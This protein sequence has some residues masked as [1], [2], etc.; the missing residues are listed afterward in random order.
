MD[1]KE[2]TQ[3]VRRRYGAFA[4]TGGHKESCCAAAAE[5]GTGYA[6]DQ[7]LYGEADLAVVPEGALDLSRG[8]GNPTG[9]AGLAA[10][11]VVVDFGCGGGIDV[12]L[13]AHKV[14]AE[15]RVVGVDM[16]PQMIE[17]AR[18]NA[19]KAGLPAEGVDFR[20]ADLT[21]TGLPDGAADVVISN[22][23]I[24]LCPDK[25]SVY[26]EAFR[27][28]RPG[29]RV[30]ISDVVLSEPI[31]PE[32]QERFRATWAGCMGGAVPE[33]NYLEM[34]GHSGFAQVEV[35]SRHP[36]ADTELDAMA[37]CPGPEFAPAVDPDDLAPVQGKVVSIKFTAVKP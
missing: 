10:G 2:I 8:C 19:L 28:L 36:L 5:A 27:L 25:E 33:A 13:A 31:D 34:V 15:G 4:E 23:V 26:R 9:F 16:T 29:G 21:T 22:C 14:G 37:R 24:N 35:V 6:V 20:V 7:G 1:V 30:A 12:I 32:L 18:D 3:E 17:R 11:E